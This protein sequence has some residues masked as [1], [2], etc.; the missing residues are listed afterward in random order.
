M[1]N[2]IKPHSQFN[3]ANKIYAVFDK[4]YL[5]DEIGQKKPDKEFFTHVIDSLG[6]GP[7]QLLFIDD[8]TENIESARSLKIN[9]IHFTNNDLAIRQISKFID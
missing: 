4:L 8:N 1:S 9:T 2:S 6:I 3:Y 7:E 5:S